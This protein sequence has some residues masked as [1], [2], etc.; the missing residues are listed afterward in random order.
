[1]TTIQKPANG[2]KYRCYTLSTELDEAR[3]AYKRRYGSEPEE[4][5]RWKMMVWAG[6]IVKEG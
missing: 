4:C 5:F 2:S 6:P 1:M 3:D